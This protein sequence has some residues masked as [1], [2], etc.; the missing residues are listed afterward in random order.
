MLTL[1]DSIVAILA[2]FA[3]LFTTPVFRHVQILIAGALL[4]PGRRTVTN[5]LRLMGLAHSPRWKFQNFHRVLN[6]AKWNARHAAKILLHLLISAFVPTGEVVVG[7]D[8]TLERRRGKKIAA[9]GIYRDA[10]RSTGHSLV[11]S[12]GLRWVCLMLLAPIPWAAYRDRVR[13]W[14]LPFLSV[15][16]PSESYAHACGRR[17]KKLVDWAIQMII[18]LRR[19]LPDRKIVLVGDNSYSVLALL[20]R[21]R[22]FKNPVTLVTRL[23]LDAALFE[24]APDRLPGQKGRPRLVGKRLPSLQS[25]AKGDTTV[26]QKIVVPYWY[27]QPQRELEI[28]SATCLWYKTGR[29][30]V[31]ICY[32]LIRDPQ[33]KF[34]LQ[35]L[36]CTDLSAQPRQILAWFMQRWQL[37]E[38]FQEVRTHLG[39]ETQ[40]QWSDLAIQ[41]TTPALLGLFSLVTLMADHLAAV[42]KLSVRRA[43]WYAKERVTFS[44]AIACVRRE[45]WQSRFFL[46]LTF[47][48]SPCATD[49]RKLRDD[50]GDIFALFAAME[51]ALAYPA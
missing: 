41:R 4:T 15:L 28:V 27:S 9:K 25:L 45:I 39:V 50:Q 7:M 33:K 51:D 48:T 20:D 30:I 37:E 12:S 2:Q 29:P 34:A 13:L 19:W 8:E 10:V 16:A 42:G 22:R 26:W 38:T 6:R 11:K 40:R 14:A 36:V 5:A 1:P 21:C 32:L 46:C 35:A 18:Q 23:R 49:T 44:D 3:P 17:H 31:P 24:P 47:S 43:A